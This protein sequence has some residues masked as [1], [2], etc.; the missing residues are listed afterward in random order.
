MTLQGKGFMIWKIPS[1]EGGSPE[2]IAAVA[3]AAGLTHVLIKIADGIYPYNVDRNTN[4]DLVPPVVAA[5]KA[6]GIQVWGWHYVYGYNPLGEAQIAARR[7]KELGLEGYIIDAEGEFKLEGRDAAAR[8]Y[9]SE[10]RRGLP[11]TPIALCSFRFPSYHP[12]F[13]W[14]EF[15]EKSDYNMPQVYWQSANNPGEQLRRCVREFQALTPFRPIMPTGPVYRN[16]GWEPTSQEIIEFL[17]TVRAL[18]LSSTNFFAW[19]YGRTILQN[20]WNAIAAYPWSPYPVPESLPRQYIDA[21]NTRD[22]NRIAELYTPNAVHVTAAQT[23]QGR[24]AIRTWYAAF[25]SESLPDATFQLT[26]ITGDGSAQP[27]TWQAISSG[28]RVPNGSDTIG[29]IDNKIAYH[30]SFFTITNS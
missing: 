13:P 16:Y 17:D 7:V 2:A 23:I 26:G 12:Q 8:Q 15:L 14:K 18:N 19:D 10:L 29:I 4:I 30:Y 1:C 6:K 5:L 28:R 21:L 3:L 27:F 9:M 24:D 20:L 25:L 11:N 22:P